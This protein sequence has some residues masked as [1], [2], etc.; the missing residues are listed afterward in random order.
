[1]A[2]CSKFLRSLL[3]LLAL[4][5]PHCAVRLIDLELKISRILNAAHVCSLLLTI[6]HI[7]YLPIGR[8]ED[9]IDLQER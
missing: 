2:F 9:I 3:Y 6:R 5:E 1:M 4:I 7:A 8:A